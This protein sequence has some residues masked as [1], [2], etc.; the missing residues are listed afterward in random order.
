ML[1]LI[2]IDEQELDLKIGFTGERDRIVRLGDGEAVL[3]DL[4][5][6]QIGGEWPF[7]GIG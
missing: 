6:V 2:G 7:A 4:L 3:A 1:V 5:A